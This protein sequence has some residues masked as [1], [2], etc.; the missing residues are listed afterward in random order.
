MDKQD[1]CAEICAL[2]AHKAVLIEVSKIPFEREFRK[3]CESNACGM[4]GKSWMCPPYVGDIDELIS[5]A[6]SYTYSIVYQT[7]GT[8]EDSYDFEGMMEAGAAMNVL[9]QK[10]RDTLSEGLCNPL[11]LGAGG[12]RICAKCAK[13]D[14][15]PCLFPDK[16]MSSLEAYG[17]SVSQLAQSCNMKY[18]H[19]E[20]T[21][22]YFGAVLFN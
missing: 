22:T 5:K 1:Y 10:I 14:D 9:T 8:L 4:Y 15:K 21:V 16:A 3:M 7:V 2:G 19:G 20:N 18:I 12:C 6:K 11:F 13:A 17:I